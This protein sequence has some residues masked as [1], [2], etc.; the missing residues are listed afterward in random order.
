MDITARIEKETGFLS[1]QKEKGGKFINQFCCFYPNR[2]G[3][4]CPHLII[5]SSATN[6]KDLMITCISNTKYFNLESGE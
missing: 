4:Q 2:C 1:I 6:A 5:I 3:L